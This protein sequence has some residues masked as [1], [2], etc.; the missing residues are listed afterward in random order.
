MMKSKFPAYIAAAVGLVLLIIAILFL[1]YVTVSGPEG[2]QLELEVWGPTE[3]SYAYAEI[4]DAYET[5][6]PFISSI[7][8]KKVLVDEYKRD[9]LSA[10]ASGEGPDVFLIR[11]T[12][13]PEFQDKIAPVPSGAIL[14]RDTVQR[15]FVD[16]VAN[17]VILDDKIYGLPLSV[18]SLALYY[19]K[20]I[21][22]IEGITN[23]PKTWDQFLALTN[24]LTRKDNLGS[25][26]RSGT[27]LGTAKNINRA[28]DILN[29]LFLQFGTNLE[30]T[31]REKTAPSSILGSKGQE[32]LQFYE[33]FADINSPYYSWNLREDYS[34]DAFQEGDLA[35]MLNYSW[36]YETIK[37]KNP[38]LN[39]AVAPLPQFAGSASEINYPNYW[40]FVVAKNKKAQGE[41]DP[42]YKD[43]VRIFESWQYLR[44]L[45]VHKG[46]PQLFT[47]IISG[48]QKEISIGI[49][50]AK[51]YVEKT[52]SP[53]A[54]RDLIEEQKTD[55]IL[56]PFVTGNLIARSWRQYDA[57][58]I[59]TT[60][61]QI[62]D[63]VHSAKTTIFEAVRLL[64]ER[65]R[66]LSRR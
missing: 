28:T 50:P 27:S 18:D 59:E 6:S 52:K 11:N 2:Y 19:N 12:W 63:D 26:T 58:A 9:L 29:M 60:M 20:D 13:I 53:A 40:V 35:M 16:V 45:T 3:D 57:D 55:P 38:R 34:I 31:T 39:F 24:Q 65:I 42:A 47:N 8:H 54:R 1:I 21:F 48:N 66:T 14:N 61:A 64:E 25:I 51:V 32:A 46:G 10:L 22:N 4:N 7:T 17:D 44:Y 15:E 33:Q 30:F 5:A 36:Q 37:R 49:N 56:G 62:I 41:I 23:P 43:D